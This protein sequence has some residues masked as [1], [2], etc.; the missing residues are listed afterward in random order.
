MNILERYTLE[1]LLS[2]SDK[3]DW[4][5]HPF[6]A[7][8]S[9]MMIYGRQGIGKS[10][11]LAQL[12]HSFQTG[13]PWMGFTPSRIGPTLMLQLDMPKGDLSKFMIRAVKNGLDMNGMTICGSPEGFN[14]R[15]KA[16]M[17]ALREECERI[18]PVAVFCDTINDAYGRDVNGNEEVRHILHTFE[19]NTGDATFIYSN[20]SRKKSLYVQTMETKQGTTMD[21]ADAF[22]GFGAFEQVPASSVELKEHGGRY[23]LVLQKHR[24]DNPGFKELDLTKNDYGFFRPT[25]P[26]AP[27]LLQWPHSLPERDRERI[28]ACSTSIRAAC[29]EIAKMTGAKAESVRAV[30]YRMKERGASP[31]AHLEDDMG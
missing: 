17:Q 14:I 8:G 26:H 25:S 1:D 6:L 18:E 27:I 11:L 10:T 31:L 13:E 24:L 19:R 20:H 29:N 22:S 28:V 21:D 9:L 12:A 15:L 23:T 30:Y 2:P 4:L 3:A 7:T 16:D 5:L